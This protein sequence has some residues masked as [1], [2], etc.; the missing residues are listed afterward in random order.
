MDQ[1]VKLDIPLSTILK[2]F[3]AFVLVYVVYLVRDVIALLFITIIFVAA[4]TPVIDYLK[5]FVNRTL[6]VSVV[7]IIILA[8]LAGILYAII[9]PLVEQ[10][11]QL[12]ENIPGWIARA[13]PYYQAAR[14]YLP[15]L[16]NSL[17]KV[18]SSLATASG[19][20][21]SATASIFGG[22]V[23]LITVIVLSF[24]FLLDEKAFKTSIFALLPP[25]KRDDVS[26]IVKKLT[27]KVGDWLRGQL[28]LG[29][30]VGTLDLIGL[31]IIGIPY[32]LTLGLISAIF[33]L[34]PVIGPIMSGAIAAAVALTIS[35][36]K[37]LF[38]IILYVI[39]QQLENHI[40]VPQIMRK[41]VGLSPVIII[42]AVVT[43]AKLLGIAGALI[44]I[45]I[46]A[47]ISVIALDWNTVK[48]IFS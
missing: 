9:P 25:E 14:D 22:V 1:K 33:E 42:I 43:G 38:V 29:L 21:F 5:K 46:A 28:I 35:P 37:A 16:Q 4:I 11:K 36:V 48:R 18:S 2:V 20:I 12:A 47:S 40:L 8:L 24:Y 27:L 19:N 41:A 10:S 26:D 30:V 17:D 7:F 6:A 39:I 44:A 45:P 3:A 34:V 23:S 15:S 13:T 32:A 31:L